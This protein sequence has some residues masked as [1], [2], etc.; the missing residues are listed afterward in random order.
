M[1]NS[2][3]IPASDVLKT[4]DSLIGPGSTVNANIK[5]LYSVNGLNPLIVPVVPLTVMS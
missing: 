1:F 3:T 5:Q 4:I 2:V